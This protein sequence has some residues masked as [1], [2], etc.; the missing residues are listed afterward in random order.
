MSDSAIVDAHVHFW[1]VER[2]SYPWLSSLPELDRSFDPPAYRE[3]TAGIEV[4]KLVFV[5]CNARPD[6][7]LEE[8]AL[9]HELAAQEPRLA[10]AVFLA[11]L[12]DEARLAS[13][14]E[15]LSALPLFR[16]VRHNIQGNGAGFC[17]QRRFVEG[18]R[19]V[20]AAGA[21][22]ELC[23]TAGQ[24]PEATELVRRCEGGRFVLD[25]CGK[26]DIRGGGYGEWAA[27][28]RELAGF[29]RVHCK[30]SGLLTE[31]SWPGQSASEVARYGRHVLACFGPER[32]MYGG[33]WPV[34]TLAGSLREWLDCSLE[35]T[36][37]LSQDERRRVYRDNALAFYRLA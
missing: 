22:F 32:V 18:V 3:A 2:L 25:H 33:D 27:S 12:E 8:A 10:G 15:A 24:L 28:I 19:R 36:R 11:D 5:E 26:P 37:E 23:A 4:E 29:E 9:A 30:L 31:A 20:H 34:V 14:L 13:R 21:H 35:V 7:N 16:G 6:Q 17:L 1:D